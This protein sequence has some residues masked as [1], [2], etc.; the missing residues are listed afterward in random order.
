MWITVS[1]EDSLWVSLNPKMEYYVILHE[2][3]FSTITIN[4]LAMPT[5]T[6]WMYPANEN[7]NIK[8]NFGLLNYSL[9]LFLAQQQNV[10]QMILEQERGAGT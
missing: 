1:I 10:I 7:S 5:T 4:K 3:G 6:I 9:Q 2:P 8:N